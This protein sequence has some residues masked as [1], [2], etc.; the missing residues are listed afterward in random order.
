MD[1]V[2][3]KQLCVNC[4]KGGGI[5]ICVGCQGCFC[6]SHFIDHRHSL[7][8]EMDR[9]SQQQDYLYKSLTENNVVHP[10]LSHIDD[11]EQ[12]SIRKIQ[13][14]AD[15]ARSD[16]S[17]F[18]NEMKSQLKQSLLK[19]KSEIE[20]GREADDYTELELTDWMEQLEKLRRIFEKPPAI[21]IVDD[22]SQPLIR[23]IQRKG[24]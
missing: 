21:E 7:D 22:Q 19:I 1:S 15:K 23:V 2:Q 12:S 17:R 14:I 20:S 11:W 9:V 3:A 8:D 16:L 10:L 13:E 6:K 24:S 18:M 4:T 5:T